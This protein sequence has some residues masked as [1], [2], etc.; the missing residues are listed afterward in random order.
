MKTATDQS[1][2]IVE[3]DT[4]FREELYNFLLAAGYETVTA[5]DTW[6]LSLITPAFRR[7]T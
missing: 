5:I 1:I 3:P 4:Q 7:T 2:L 6:P